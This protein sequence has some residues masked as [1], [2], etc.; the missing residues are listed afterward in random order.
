MWNSARGT[1]SMNLRSTEKADR[2]C[3]MIRITDKHAAAGQKPAAVC[4]FGANGE[5]FTFPG[6]CDRMNEEKA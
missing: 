1:G 6:A 3:P 4:V 2:F 5:V